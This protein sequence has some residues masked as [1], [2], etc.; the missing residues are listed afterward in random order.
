MS[1]IQNVDTSRSTS[2]F[3]LFSPQLLPATLMLGGGVT[4]YAVETYITATI[5]PSIV[6][7]IGGLEL[8]SWMTTLFVAAAVLGSIFVATRP[9]GIGLRSVYVAGAL[10]F[11]AGS[12]VCTLAPAMPLVLVGRTVQGFGAGIL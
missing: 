11:G 8:L 5:A 1:S 4:L 6:R 7:D 12:L 9:R 10:V 3:T 2:I